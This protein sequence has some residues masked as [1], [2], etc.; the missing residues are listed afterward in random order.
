MSWAYPKHTFETGDPLDCEAMNDT[1]AA[2]ASEVNGNLNQHNWQTDTL[3]DLQGLSQVEPSIGLQ[4]YEGG[5]TVDPHA[6][7][8]S[9]AVAPHRTRW[10]PIDGT[11]VEFTSRGGKAFVI[12]SFQVHQPSVVAASSGLNFAIELDGVVMNDT[13]LGTGDESNDFLDTALGATVGGGEVT[14]DYGTSPSIRAAQ[15]KCLVSG[16]FQLEPGEHIVRLVARNLFTINGTPP[17]YI[18]QRETIILSMWA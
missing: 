18:S 16:V 9:M 11:E 5:A 13:L 15:T 3:L 6:A 12:I 8:S 4:I 14:Y 10:S 17:Q 7:T 2:Y 1:I